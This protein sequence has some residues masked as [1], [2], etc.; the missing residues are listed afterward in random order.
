MQKIA[1]ELVDKNI[2]KTLIP[3]RPNSNAMPI[4][5]LAFALSFINI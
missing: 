1:A 2:V 4:G 3:L 5:Q